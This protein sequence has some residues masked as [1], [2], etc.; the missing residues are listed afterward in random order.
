MWGQISFVLSFYFFLRSLAI[1]IENMAT[2]QK[3]VITFVSTKGQFASIK[4]CITKN[5][6]PRPIITNVGMAMPSVLRVRIVAIA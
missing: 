6:E 3:V 4:P 1:F 5:I 2:E